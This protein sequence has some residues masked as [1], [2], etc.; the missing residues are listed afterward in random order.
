MYDYFFRGKAELFDEEKEEVINE[1]SGLEVEYSSNRPLSIDNDIDAELASGVLKNAYIEK[2]FNDGVIS[3]LS[4]KYEITLTSYGIDS[5]PF[6][7]FKYLFHG[8]VGISNRENGN[9]VRDYE[10]V[11]VQYESRR[12]LNV[13]DGPDLALAVMFVKDAYVNKL[14][15]ENMGSLLNEHTFVDVLSCGLTEIED[16]KPPVLQTTNRGFSYIEFE[17]VYGLACSLQKSSS[18]NEDCIWL[19]ISKP[20]VKHLVPGLGWKTFHIPEHAL[21]SS[22]MHLNQEQVKMLM[23]YLQRFVETGDL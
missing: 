9:D 13:N 7:M 1:H 6:R 5:R 12:R 20:E 15:A 16:P 2:L 3:E 21:I 4:D 10:D 17:D 19:G 18:G 11:T 22:R 14:L 8:S 23:P